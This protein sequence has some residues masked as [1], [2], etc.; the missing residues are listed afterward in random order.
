[1]ASEQPLAPPPPACPG[2]DS[3]LAGKQ[4]ACQGC[5]NQSACSSGARKNSSDEDAYEISRR[6]SRVKRIILILSGKGGVGKST[7]STCLARA[8]ALDL[9]LNVGLLDVD[10]CGP[11]VPT[12]TGLVGED[13][14][15][16]ASGWSPVFLTDNLSVMSCGF[17]LESADTSVVW[18]GTKKNGLIRQF[19][20]DVDWGELDYLIVDTPPGTS[21]EHLSLVSLLKHCHSLTGALIVTTPQEVALADVRK[22]VDFCNKVKL[23]VFGLVQNMSGFVCPKC[24]TESDIFRKTDGL[25]QLSVSSGIPIVAEIPLDPK[26]AKACD[27]GHCCF[28]KHPE[29]AAVIAFKQAV[30]ALVRNMD[31]DNKNEKITSS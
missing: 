12:T 26:I 19:L 8:L 15:M 21:D 29:S 31:V 3:D 18:R 22:Q 4:S 27:E 5:P 20:R 1:M 25:Q 17:L 7:V 14:H 28:E 13:I 16:S 11:S 6:L 24:K 23:R 30:T 2:L 10:V 9:N